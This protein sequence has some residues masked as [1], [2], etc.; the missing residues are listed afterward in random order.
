VSSRGDA[1]CL[2]NSRERAKGAARAA[3]RRRALRLAPLYVCTI[4]ALF[5]ASLADGRPVPGASGC[6]MTPAGSFWHAD[7]SRLPVHPQSRAWIAS[8][9]RNAGL[10]ADFGSGTYGGGPIGIP[11]ATVPRT[12][13]RVRVVFEYT[14]ESDRGPYPIPRR[15]PIEGG[16]GSSGDRHVVVVDRDACRLFELFGAY[17]RNGGASWRAGSGA[18]WNLRSNAMRPPGWTS[19]D[20]AGLPILPGLVRH[21]EVAAGEI[22]HVIRFTAP[23]T[24]DAYVWPASHKAGNSGPSDP[25]MGAWFRLRADYDISAFSP[26]NQVI[27]R[28]LKKHGMV[29]A[30]NGSP[31]FLSGVPDPRWDNDDLNALRSIPGAAF[32]AVDVSRLRVSTTSY[33]VRG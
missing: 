1:D 19:G 29:L 28:A 22:D 10:K 5:G 12:Q 31:F 18:T 14:D 25:P 30:D 3:R 16:P 27:L 7:V 26:K 32:E 4:A 2:G 13:P 9:G 8:I 23:R 33:K 11:Y 6:P 17:P 20:A 21:D 24:A 15:V